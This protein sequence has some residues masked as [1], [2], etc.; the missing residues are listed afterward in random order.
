MGWA[1][2]H[3]EAGPSI[4]SRLAAVGPARAAIEQYHAALR[5]VVDA[6][7]KVCSELERF[8]SE[9]ASQARRFACER[10]EV[11]TSEARE[12]RDKIDALER[13]LRTARDT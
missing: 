6:E 11:G 13:E 5:V 4:A 1:V 10:L 12:M 9:D 3:V 2:G 8:R 7:L